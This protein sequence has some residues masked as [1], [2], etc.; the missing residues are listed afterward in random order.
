MP[1]DIYYPESELSDTAVFETALTDLFLFPDEGLGFVVVR[2]DVPILLKWSERIPRW[3]ESSLPLADKPSWNRVGLGTTHGG[4]S[5]L[6][7]GQVSPWHS[8]KWEQ[9]FIVVEGEL[10]VGLGPGANQMKHVMRMQS[11]DLLYFLFPYRDRVDYRNMAKG[12]TTVLVIGGKVGAWPTETMYIIP[13]E[14]RPFSRPW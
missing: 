1:G 3:R 8:V 13:G 10:E 2:I 14:K 11:G 6:P 5:H 4:E 9:Y 7:Y 12:S